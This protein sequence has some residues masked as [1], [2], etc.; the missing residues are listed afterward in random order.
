MSKDFLDERERS[1]EY[2]YFHEQEMKL[3]SKLHERLDR[4]THKKALRENTPIKDDALLDVE[5]LVRIDGQGSFADDPVEQLGLFRFED[6]S[7]GER[8]NRLHWQGS[9]LEA[10]FSTIYLPGA[11]DAGHMGEA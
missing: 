9:R 5:C 6:G 7:P 3:I 1:L 11:F 2:G 4:E 10:R 8:P